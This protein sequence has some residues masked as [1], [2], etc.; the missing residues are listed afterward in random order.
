MLTTVTRARPEQLVVRAQPGVLERMLVVA[1]LFL[2]QFGTPAD[3]FT[4]TTSANASAGPAS[5]PLLVMGTLGIV[6]V[7]TLG[8]NGNG[9]ALVRAVSIEPFLV[10]FV[11]LAGV[12]A[13]WSDSFVD[14]VTAVVNF[15]LLTLLAYTLT[16][17][18]R[19]IEIVQL[20]AI[21]MAIGTVMHLIWVFG[22]PSYGRAANGW[23]GL[24][25][26]KNALGTQAVQALPF[27]LLL[28]R[29]RPRWRFQLWALAIAAAVLL[30]G[31]QSKT[32]LA[33]G[34]LTVAASL[35]YIAFRA[36]KTLYGAVVITLTTTS[37]VA[38]LF[39]TA[40]LS[41]LAE[42][43]EKDAT[44]TGRTEM[45][46]IIISDIADRPWLGHGFFG[47]WNGYRSPAHDVWVSQAWAPTHA[48][49]AVLEVALRLGFVGLLL[50]VILNARALARA[51]SLIRFVPG[52]MALFPLVYF[53]LVLMAS[54][55]ESGVVPQRFGWVF[56]VVC[57]LAA[58]ANHRERHATR[59]VQAGQP[60]AETAVDPARRSQRE[61][62]TA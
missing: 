25:T 40:N 32:M 39:A 20:A 2:N 52:P 34:A 6:G 60:D 62:T 57:L 17:R 51:T 9:Q 55:T 1:V 27:F 33:S 15:S 36:R 49:N 46:P 13:F 10:A 12:S 31:S 18:F 37:I 28:A 3:W 11:L 61:T 41:V 4:V 19:F 38:A 24:G 23:T 21:A 35:C 53:T 5:N 45:W 29:A 30:V 44:L 48:H 8:L 47:Y 26:Q 54:I 43:L 22:L 14:A 59:L 42:Y 16:I 58:G 56:F 7:L 50:F